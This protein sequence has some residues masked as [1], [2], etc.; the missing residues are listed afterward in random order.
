M[1]SIGPYHDRHCQGISRRALLQVGGR[2]A[3]CLARP[4]LLAGRAS[5]AGRPASAPEVN[6][7]FFLL[8]GGPSQYETFD[9]KPEAAAEIRGPF[10][11]IPTAVDGLR[12][13]EH[14]PCLAKLAD[15]FTTI[16]CMHHDN[17]NH[18]ESGAYVLSG[19]LPN[20]GTRFPNQGAVIAKYGR[21]GPTA[22]PPFV[23]LGPDLFDCAGE[24]TA[25]DA[26]TLGGGYAPLVVP[27]PREPLARV[28]PV[29]PPPEVNEARFA[30]RRSL[31]A[32]VEAY[33][34]AV[35]DDRAAGFDAAYQRAFSIVTSPAA[36][37][38]LDL[39]LEPPE[40]RERYGNTLPGQGALMARR[41]VE[42]GVRFV[43]VNWGRYVAMSGWDTH[44]TGDN[45]GGTLPQMAD[46]L[47]PTLDRVVPALFE[48]LEQ[49]GLHRNTFVVVTG[50]FGRT[51]KLNNTAGRDHWPGVYPALL[52]GHGVPRGLVIG[53]SDRDG[54]WP[55]GPQVR[56]EH[57][58]ATLYRL[59]GLD[60]PKVFGALGVDAPAA[61]IPGIG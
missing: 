26:G 59:L 20:L 15:R 25:Q 45:M 53:Q 4:D 57:V 37:R 46:F 58:T 31:L 16:R 35:E 7:I 55:D 14:L 8:W 17:P 32:Q 34:R 36:K 29:Q 42:A 50:E 24:I 21:P 27:D 52:F 44:G 11:P 3:A 12:F 56:P 30:R 41:L 51:H 22:L 1:F 43:Q 28:A 18:H 9:P 2:S 61:G 39:S 54:L 40:M 10:R 49:R 19:R 47:L 23:R 48:D 5:A 13:C 38:A 60:V 6:C 33:Q